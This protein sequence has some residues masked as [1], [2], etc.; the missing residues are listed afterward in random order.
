MTA[1]KSVDITPRGAQTPEGIA[2]INAATERL[3]KANAEC[4]NALEEVLAIGKSEWLKGA[5][6]V[7]ALEAVAERKAATEEFLRALAGVPKT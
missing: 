1:N 3:E 7:A 5:A 2:R 6:R 4:A